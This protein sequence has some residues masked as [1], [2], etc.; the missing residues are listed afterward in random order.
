[1][2]CYGYVG[3]CCFVLLLFYGVLL[4]A[5]MLSFV[6]FVSSVCMSYCLCFRRTLA[7][8]SASCSS[9]FWGFRSLSASTLILL[10]H[11][12]I[13]DR[14]GHRLRLVCLFMSLCYYWLT[15]CVVVLF[16]CHLSFSVFRGHP[17]RPR[18][19]DIVARM[20]VCLRCAHLPYSTPLWNR[21]GAVIGCFCRLRE[22][23]FTSQNWLK[24]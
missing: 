4:F 22:E 15:M 14:G 13:L 5:M 21:F 7:V 17:W 20:H 18:S 2:L 3:W 8:C 16:V 6:V 11:L 9:L 19:C 1:M 23:R 10:T 24:G 12:R